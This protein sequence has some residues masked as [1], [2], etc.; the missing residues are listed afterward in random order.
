MDRTSK[1]ERPVLIYDENC[2]IC[3][4]TARW[5][6][7]NLKGDALE[8][9]P[10]QA[11]G[12]RNRFPFMEKSICMKAM[13]LVL[14]NGKVLSGEKALPE[15]INRLRRYGW[16]ASFFRLPGSGI[17]SHAFYRWF[18]ERRYGIARLLFPKKKRPA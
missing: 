2:P 9:L 10:C 13:Q 16:V 4:K 1:E 12:A 18:A 15:I 11:E 3:R 14:P 7:G 6:E 17:L 8:M 5:V